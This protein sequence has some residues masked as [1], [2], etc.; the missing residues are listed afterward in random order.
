GHA[1][2]RTFHRL[3][4]ARVPYPT[5]WPSLAS[6][7]ALK[8]PPHPF[9][10]SAITLPHKE[11]APAYT[12]PGQ[13]AARLGI[14]YDPVFVDGSRA[15]PLAFGAPRG[16]RR[17]APPAG[18]LLDRRTLLRALDDIQRLAERSA[19]ARDY[20]KQQHRA[21]TLLASRRTRSAFDL[22]AEP[23]GVRARY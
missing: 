22:R 14:E 20:E 3:L 16:G 4:N 11:G 7:V 12:R 8:R 5:D 18:R 15:R 17:G 19:A 10:P 1:P 13:F 6:V 9:L 21:F 23:E 2:D